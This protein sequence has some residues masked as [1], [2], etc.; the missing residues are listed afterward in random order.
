VGVCVNRIGTDA[1]KIKVG[2]APVFFEFLGNA[3]RLVLHES[4][5]EPAETESVF[6]VSGIDKNVGVLLLGSAANVVGS[7]AERPRYIDPSIDPVGAL[8]VRLEQASGGDGFTRAGIARDA[9]KLTSLEEVVVYSFASAFIEGSQRSF[10]MKVRT[11]AIFSALVET[12]SRGIALEHAI[13]MYRLS[14]GA[15]KSTLAGIDRIVV[16]SPIYV[17]QLAI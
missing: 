13:Q 16:G 14:D 6:M 2:D 5:R 17:E 8:L 7:G 12:K 4:Y 9:R 10:P 15:I 1:S 3:V 11:L